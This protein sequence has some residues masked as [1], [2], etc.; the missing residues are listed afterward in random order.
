MATNELKFAQ[1]QR[2]SLDKQV[3]A[4]EKKVRDLVNQLAKASGVT[5]G[6]NS[7]VARAS[8]SA[9]DDETLKQMWEANKT[10]REIALAL[11]KKSSSVNSRI[12]RL[13]LSRRPRS[14]EQA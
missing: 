4:A 2:E 7:K 1:L 8:Y 11:G 10:A 6:N 3:H 5:A 9:A 12:A 13:G 14:K